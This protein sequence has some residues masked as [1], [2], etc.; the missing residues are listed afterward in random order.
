MN[1]SLSVVLERIAKLLG[2]TTD[3]AIAKALG[4]A[5]QTLSTWK[6]RGTIP[7]ERVCDFAENKDVSLDYLLLGKG[8]GDFG[9]GDIDPTLIEAIEHELKG[10]GQK[11]VNTL[12]RNYAYDLSL[13]YNRINRQIVPGKNYEALISEE[14]KYFIEIARRSE[15]YFNKE[16]KDREKPYVHEEE[17]R[18]FKK[19][20][21]ADISESYGT[22]IANPIDDDHSKVV[23]QDVS[24]S[25]NQVA[26]RD[27][28]N[29]NSSKDK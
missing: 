11:T 28:V 7:Y 2:V 16:S 9:G 17:Q 4:V 19:I 3:T 20:T 10:Y 14:V 5:P 1:I 25:N 21:G 15:D 12:L 26:G 22:T 6:R 27:V 29:K 23:N 13:I 8:K 24:G 18:M